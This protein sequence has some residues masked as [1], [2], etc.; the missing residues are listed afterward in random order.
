MSDDGCVLIVEDEFLIADLWAEMVA[1]LG[2]RVCGM[3]ATADRAVALAVE[4]RP[5]LVLMDV[6][7][8]EATRDGVDAAVDIHSAVG[9]PVIFI[10][11]SKEPATVARVQQDHPA[12][13]LFK[14]VHFEHLRATIA[15]VCDGSGPRPI[16]SSGGRI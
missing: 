8:G 10:T 6:R 5:S 11:G 12:A 2:M 1:E 13:L 3:A 7:L 15:K 9:C 16:I 14:P 4:H